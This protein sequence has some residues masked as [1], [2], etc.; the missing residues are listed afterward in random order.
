MMLMD[1]V[2]CILAYY[3][4]LEFLWGDALK[5]AINILNQVSSKSVAKTPYDYWIE[6]SLA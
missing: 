2:T 6:K 4:L 5:P 3:S 1:M